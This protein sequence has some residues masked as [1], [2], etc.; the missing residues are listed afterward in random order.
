MFANAIASGPMIPTSDLALRE[1]MKRWAAHHR[2]W[3]YM[4]LPDLEFA[5]HIKL[6]PKTGE[7]E[8][9]TTFARHYYASPIDSGRYPGPALREL[10]N[11]FGCSKHKRKGADTQS[12][13]RLNMPWDWAMARVVAFD[14]IN[15]DDGTKRFDNVRIFRGGIHGPSKQRRDYRLEN[16]L[17]AEQWLSLYKVLAR[18]IFSS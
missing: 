16:S 10:R 3:A 8:R 2:K 13:T 18:K 1:A 4:T 5:G 15:E 7:R 14:I 12:R 11:R 6:N 17:T 9:Q